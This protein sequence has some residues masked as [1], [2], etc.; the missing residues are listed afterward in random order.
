M[1]VKFSTNLWAT[2]FEIGLLL[3]FGPKPEFKRFLL[4]NQHK[5]IR[6][7]PCESVVSTEER[8]NR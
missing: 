3:N 8:A 2:D 7:H 6:V 5:K 4:D 1:R